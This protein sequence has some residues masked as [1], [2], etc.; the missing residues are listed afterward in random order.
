MSIAELDYEVV[1]RSRIR[2]VTAKR[3]RASVQQKPPV[4]LHRTIEAAPLV[5]H[6][7]RARAA[8]SDGVRPT[9]TSTLCVVLARTLARDPVMN[10]WLLE[11]EFRRFDEVHLAVAVATEDGLVPPVLR[12]DE[13]VDDHGTAEA[14]ARLGEVARS[15][16]LRPEHLA[17]STFTVTGLGAHGI[18]YFTPIL[19][20]PHIGILGVGS[21]QPGPDGAATRLPLSLTFDHAA[22]DGVDG[23]RFLQ[24]LADEI[25]DLGSSSGDAA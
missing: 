14:L 11:D 4:T 13:L 10:A 2:R 6:L 19:N 17:P 12:P 21:L 15:G 7:E 16:E 5:A 9:L 8:A 3:M 18:E 1:P 24:S 23:A 20:P 22:V 25:T